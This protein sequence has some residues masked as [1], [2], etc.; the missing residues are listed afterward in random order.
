M[1][2]VNLYL[3]VSPPS[4]IRLCPSRNVTGVV[5]RNTTARAISSGRPRSPRE[6]Y[7]RVEGMRGRFGVGMG[8]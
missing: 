1:I 3:A 5:A 8:G 6:L 7:W 4:T 2:A